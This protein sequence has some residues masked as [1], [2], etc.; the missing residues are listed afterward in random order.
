[1][2]LLVIF[3]ALYA[4]INFRTIYV[5]GIVEGLVLIGFS[6]YRFKKKIGII[7]LISFTIG[8]GISFIRPNITRK[9]YQSLVVEVR[10]NYYIVNCG[11]ERLY[12]YEK[13]NNREI[14]DVLLIKGDKTDLE[15]A[16]T[17]SSFDFA[18]YLNNKGVYH[19]LN[20]SSINVKFSNPI[21]INALRKNYLSHFNDDTKS[22]I[23][24]LF[25][26]ISENDETVELFRELHLTRLITNSGLFLD[27]FLTIFTYLFS[28]RLK[29]KIASICGLSIFAIY[30]VFTFPRF[31]VIKFLLLHV[32][33]WF[34][35]YILK[36]RFN[37]LELVSILGISFLIFDYHLAY[38]DSFFL[39]F[40]IP[41]F[42]FFFNSSF[43]KIKKWKKAILVPLVV[44][45]SF[46]PFSINYYHEISPLS[47]VVQL[48]FTPVLMFY[49]I[50]TLISFIGIP[51][52]PLLN[53]FTW[54]LNNILSFIK[55]IFIKIYVPNGGVV[56]K[57]IYEFIYLMVL[58]FLSIRLIDIYKWLISFSLTAT[59]L[60][61]APIRPTLK[62]FVSFINVGQGD[63]CLIHS[64][65]TN[66]MID[67]GGLTYKDIAK[68]SLIPYLKSEQIYQIDLLITTHNDFDHMGGVNSLVNNFKVLNYRTNYEYFPI[69][70]GNLTL[71]NYKTYRDMWKE[72]ND[73]S[74]FIGF[75][76][77]GYHFLITGDAPKKIE[78][79]IIK[80]YPD[81]KCDY[82]KV[83]HH[84]SKTSTS[85][86]FINYIRPKEAIVSCGYKNKYGHPHQEVIN[87]LKKYDVKIRRTDLEGTIKYSFV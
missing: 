16:K 34:N 51:I 40:Y 37:Y 31:V 48:A 39:S 84:G 77:N 76:M 4:G 67:T 2:I 18:K 64:K 19:E 32:L 38:Q 12:V 81:L 41:V 87:T 71:Y 59:S 21:K 14:G 7:T 9:K 8:I 17:E 54:L 6:F 45:I 72:E 86:E 10:E 36:K 61:V 23:S 70:I 5:L 60:F 78:R 28:K 11:L 35:E 20:P 74:L 1:M 50:L 52:Y 26:G 83:G 30:S 27:L 53:G 49:A 62:S 66:I 42:I 3:L 82:L 24:S 57:V 56:L 68:E 44:A 63:S 69:D 43:K 80:D 29:K 13:G 22:L 15:F 79:R 55:P 85:D 47:F 65:N 46:V 75:E 25:F 33:K 58:Y 73:Y